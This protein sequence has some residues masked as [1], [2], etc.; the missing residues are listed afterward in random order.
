[1]AKYVVLR[2]S[3]PALIKDS[4]NL[5]HEK[6]YKLSQFAVETEPLHLYIAVM[7]LVGQ[8]FHLEPMTG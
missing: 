5:W 3:T 1:M 2:E 6:G 8:R 4:M 7:E